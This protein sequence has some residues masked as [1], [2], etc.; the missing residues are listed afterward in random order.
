MLSADTAP[1]E[2]AAVPP[3][4]ERAVYSKHLPL[5]RRVALRTAQSLPAGITYDDVLRAGWVGLVAALRA[6]PDA[7]EAEFNTYAAYRVRLAVLEY[8]KS[9]DP[10]ARRMRAVSIRITEA[11]RDLVARTGRV[12]EEHEVASELGLDLASYASLLEG[13]AE[14]GWVRLEL[15]AFETTDMETTNKNTSDGSTL[16]SRVERIIVGL[17]DQYQVVLGLYYQEQCDLDE[18]GEVLGVGR[19]RA[20]QLHAQAVHLVRGQLSGG[21]AA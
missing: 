4:V 5:V 6:R 11:I 3:G 10:N 18:I 21:F 8:L 15:T 20:C 14:A 13:I 9:L 7:D 19:G 17:P 12:P 2:N 16:G 1:G